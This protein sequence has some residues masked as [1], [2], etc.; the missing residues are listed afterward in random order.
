MVNDGLLRARR[1][2]AQRPRPLILDDDGDLVYDE[3]ALQGPE[4]FAKLR[5]TDLVDAGVDSLAWCIMWGIAKGSESSVRYWQTQKEGR[6]F[7]PNMPDPTPVVEAFC[8]RHGIE[9]FGSIRMNDCHDAF[10]M[11]SPQ[12]LYPL[13]IEHP[14]FL[15]GDQSQQGGVED[16]LAAAMWSGLNYALPAVREDRLWWIEHTAKVYDLDGIDLNFFRMPWLF[17]PGE[18]ADHIPL[19][20]E[21]MRRARQLVDAAAAQRQRPLLLGV[22]VADTVETCRRSGLD[23]ESWLQED[24]VDRLL[25]GGGYASFCTPAA[26]MIALGHRYD[27]P[28]Y[29]CINCPG[30]FDRGA[31]RGFEA[32]RGAAANFWQ[33]G[34]DGIY[35]WNYQYLNTPH[36]AYG[37]PYPEDYG[38]L[39]AIANPAHLARLDKIFSVNPRPLEQYARAST[40]CPLPMELGQQRRGLAVRIGDDVST[41]STLL[42]QVDLENF[43]PGDELHIQFND[44]ILDGGQ[45]REGEWTLERTALRQ[46]LNELSIAVRKR[47]M[48]ALAPLVLAEVR[49]LVRYND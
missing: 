36:I 17:K 41:A 5:L 34:A 12:L 24:L 31:G 9:A 42:L 23:V 29:P 6:P 26:E 32:L 16:G 33:A 25:A 11:P 7:Q 14:E 37:Q 30:T 18:E 21:F 27:V 8:R 10:S 13:K 35:L 2:A 38:H 46:G 49:V 44:L 43:A 15:L 1:Q 3:R 39:A 19:M 47:G 45:Q 40:S 22:R 28:V 20:T 4:A 48:A